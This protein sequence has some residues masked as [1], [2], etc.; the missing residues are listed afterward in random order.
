MVTLKEI[1]KEC[2]VSPATV[3][4][5]LNGKPK[6]SEETRQRVLDTVEKRG[7]RPNYIAQGLR[8]QKTKTIGIIAED[9]AQFTTPEIVDGI[10]SRCEE[11]GYRAVVKNLRLYARWSD[12]WYDNESSYHSILDPTLKELESIRV[13]GIIY[14]AGH[15]R[16]IHC[17]SEDFKTPAVMAY[18]FTDNRRVPSVAIDDK[19]S[20]CEMIHYLISRGHRKIGVIGGRENN[21][22]TQ[23]RLQGYQKALFE[24]RILFNPSWVRYADWK[25]EGAY[26]EAREL[27]KE[28]VTAVFC[29]ADRMAGG[30]Y[31]CLDEIGLRAGRD[32][33]VAGF[34]NHD[35]AEYFVPGLTTMALPLREI[36]NVSADY[37]LKQMEEAQEEIPEKIL[38]PC[39][40]TERESVHTI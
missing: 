9:I 33:A 16:V 30:V 19:K 37:L 34:D 13:D 24:N 39:T 38:I 2:R 5:I 29:M 14:I 11:K 6:V 20:A 18:A 22:H 26:Q 36:G 23:Q 25:K 35:I 27:L 10:M 12:S 32:I 4:N 28:D 3:S 17:F 8:N 7:Y 40:F 15:A 31:R 1:A 21:I